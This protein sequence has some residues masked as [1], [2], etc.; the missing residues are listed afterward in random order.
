MIYDIKLVIDYDYANSALGGR[1]LA[2]L[3]PLA[4]DPDQRLISGAL[5]ITPTPEER[6]DRCDD[7]GWKLHGQLVDRDVRVFDN[8]MQQGGGQQ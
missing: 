5:T 2:C 3:L 4:H 7:F 6:R 8:V 1:H